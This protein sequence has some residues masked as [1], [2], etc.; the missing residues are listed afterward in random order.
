MGFSFA[1]FGL[2]LLLVAFRHWP[3]RRYRI[4][5]DE[6]GGPPL[7]APFLKVEG[8]TGHIKTPGLPPVHRGSVQRSK[9]L[10][11]LPRR[12]LL[13]NG[14]VFVRV[15]FDP[16]FVKGDIEV[17]MGTRSPNATMSVSARDCGR[18][19]LPIYMPSCWWICQAVQA[20][21]VDRWRR[22]AQKAA[23]M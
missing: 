9:S 16:V 1:L 15:V 3:F 7:F 23:A 10:K 19:T 8:D 22:L 4:R 18:V 12:L 2:G 14:C 6:S 17:A 21:R 13:S 20:G 5:S 11:G